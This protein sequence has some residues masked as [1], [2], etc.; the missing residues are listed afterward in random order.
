MTPDQ[1]AKHYAS[2]L[3]G[4]LLKLSRQASELLPEAQQALASELRKRGLDPSEA[5]SDAPV[6]LPPV[7]VEYAEAEIDPDEQAIIRRF[8]D[9]PEAMVAKSVLDSVGIERF[10]ADE[11]MIRMN[12]LLSNL[13]GGL[14]LKVRQEDVN[15]ALDVLDQPIPASFDVDGIG[16]YQQ[17]S[18]PKCSSLDIAFEKFDKRWWGVAVFVNFP[19]L[20]PR[21]RW[22][23]W[24]CGHSWKDLREA[25][26]QQQ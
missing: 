2:L 11:N 24:A 18:C 20:I 12:W 1:L 10:L 5:E 19:V 14:K 16:S 21:N 15:A 13:F 9:F 22:Y 23:C 26:I 4:E 3:D 7:P 17:P 6:S 8:R 25:E